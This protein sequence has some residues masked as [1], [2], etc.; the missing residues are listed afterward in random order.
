MKNKELCEIVIG[1]TA[2]RGIVDVPG[3][4]S[5]SI[6]LVQKSHGLTD[7]LLNSG[8]NLLQLKLIDCYLR[9][10][11]THDPENREVVFEKAEFETLLGGKRI[12][13]EEV[14]KALF[15]FKE[16][17]IS[18]VKSRETGETEEIM[19]FDRAEIGYFEGRLLIDLACSEAAI[20]YLFALEE[21]GYIKYPLMTSLSIPNL[22]TYLLYM[23][24]LT[25]RFRG[26]W[27]VDLLALRSILGCSATY[28]QYFLF[29]EK[30]LK[31]AHVKITADC[32]LRYEYRAVKKADRTLIAFQMVNEEKRSQA[33]IDEN[34]YKRDM[35]KSDVEDSNDSVISLTDEFPF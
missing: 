18:V 21:N 5:T 13:T 9:R 3:A 35:V 22:H 30:V 32:D 28:P 23:Y 16:K 12:K 2:L 27:Q 26:H 8:F 14:V 24:L 25:N 1:K 29:N 20:P 11:N 31:T 17:Y 10:I 34:K 33:V 19:L 7:A 4:E 15:D 6:P